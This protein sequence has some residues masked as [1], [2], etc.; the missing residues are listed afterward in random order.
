M[1]TQ[2]TFIRRLRPSVPSAIAAGIF[3]LLAGCQKAPAP[4]PVASP[5]P[6]LTVEVVTPQKRDLATSLPASGSIYPWHEASVGAEVGGLRVEQV[7]ANVG[8]HVKKGQVL[9]RLA[10][11]TVST[12]LAQQDASVA[13]AHATLEQA[14]ANAVRAE[15]LHAAQAMSSQDLLAAQTSLASARARLQSATALQASQRLRLAKTD[16]VAPDSGTIAA[17]SVS[18]GQVTST[19]TELFRL[20]RQDKLEWRAE[21]PGQ[22]LLSVTAGQK[23]QLQLADGSI[24]TGSV[25]LVAPTLDTASRSGLAYIDVPSG[26]RAKPGMFVSGVI[27]TGTSGGVT[28]PG[29]SVVV[30]DGISY[31]M[32]VDAVDKVRVVKVTP[33]RQDDKQVELT[34]EALPADVRVVTQGAAFLNEGDL[35]RV[36]GKG[37]QR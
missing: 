25:R 14:R 17:R 19:G 1:T 8:D 11:D 32:T 4:A 37:V 12:D 27:L 33:G 2:T 9:A 21:L 5:K 22:S 24:I 29:A 30:R 34:G 28:V 13:E 15:K 23:A 36:V 31:V 20:V 3:L 18:L 26:S 7:L 35:V 16:I 10:T 6:A